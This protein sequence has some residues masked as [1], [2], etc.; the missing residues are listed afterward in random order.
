MPI[1]FSAGS[2]PATRSPS[3]DRSLTEVMAAGIKKLEPVE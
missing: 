3:S 2:R 1:R